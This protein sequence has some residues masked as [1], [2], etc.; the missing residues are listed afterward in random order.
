MYDR[1]NIKSIYLKL[2]VKIKH[3]LV[4]NKSKEFFIFLF[5]LFVAS[6]FWLLQTLDRNYEAEL[7]I[8]VRLENVPKEIMITSE[9]VTELKVRIKDR[10][11]GLLG[12]FIGKTFLPIV[13]DFPLYAAKST[14]GVLKIEAIAFES[15][16]LSR[17]NTS[18]QLLA[19]TSDSLD[20]IYSTDSPRKVPVKLA[21]KLETKPPYYISDT[22]FSPD[23]VLAYAPDLYL[24]SLRAAYTETLHISDLSD[25]LR[26]RVKIGKLKGVR[27]IPDEVK[28]IV[29][30]D[31]Y[32]EKSVEIPLHGVN[33][34]P[35]KMLRTFP[36]KV[37]ISFRV[38][39]KDYQK[40]TADDFII[41]VS[42]EELLYLNSDKYE[43]RLKRFPEGISNIR[44]LPEAVDFLIEQVPVYDN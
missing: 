22:L 29:P 2:S 6:A 40:I 33:F 35:G 3:F 16:V 26:R 37:K 31:I 11:T 5:F 7:S 13:V 18:T 44:I 28:V 14:N 21:G 38:G 24:D 8:P 10:G 4:S 39:M 17:L 25:T 32:T 34:P 27:F 42:Y 15:Q 1:K 23:S 19:I 43:I 20:F 36:A 30:V 41:N 12:Y 9:P